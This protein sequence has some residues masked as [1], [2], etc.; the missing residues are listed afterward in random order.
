MN[1]LSSVACRTAMAQRALHGR[2]ALGAFARFV[3]DE[4]LASALRVDTDN[5]GGRGVP[6]TL[7]SCRV[8]CHAFTMS[9]PLPCSNLA[10]Q[11]REIRI[12]I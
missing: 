6:Q 1:C 11:T 3:I 5:Y 8:L 12:E 7:P 4:A 2:A 10:G 9:R